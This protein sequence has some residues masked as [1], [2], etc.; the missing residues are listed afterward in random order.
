MNRTIAALL[1]TALF[2]AAS[3]GVSHAQ[4]TLSVRL[5]DVI[6]SQGTCN[7]DLL[8]DLSP[9]QLEFTDTG[10]AYPLFNDFVSSEGASSQDWYN[11]PLVDYIVDIPG[12][13]TWSW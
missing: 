10:V 3:P 6:K 8:K 13:G 12:V 7:I 2:A 4:E 1:L 11:S 5:S 9:E